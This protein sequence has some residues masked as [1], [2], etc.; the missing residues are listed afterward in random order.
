M[1]ALSDL[2][3]EVLGEDGFLSAHANCTTQT[4]TIEVFL[5]EGGDSFQ[6]FAAETRVRSGATALP[7]A[8]CEQNPLS[9]SIIVKALERAPGLRFV[10]GVGWRHA[11]SMA[12]P[13]PPPP[14]PSFQTRISYGPVPPGPSPPP[15]NPPPFYTQAADPCKCWIAP[16]L[17]SLIH[18]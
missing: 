4:T 5:F 18:D 13:A 17:G 2:N 9:C 8:F 7:N 3:S 10:P 14:P 15:Q 6:R 1:V 16:V 11:Y 12:P